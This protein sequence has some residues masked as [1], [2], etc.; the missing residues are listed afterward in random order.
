MFNKA[1]LPAQD[2]QKARASLNMDNARDSISSEESD[3]DGK[4][5]TNPIRFIN[6]ISFTDTDGG[7]ATF[8]AQ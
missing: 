3:A 1:D 6:S 2:K 5:R 7:R 8:K 4:Q